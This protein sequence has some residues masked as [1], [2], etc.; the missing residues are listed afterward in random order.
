[1][2]AGHSPGRRSEAE[3]GCGKVNEKRDAALSVT[4]QQMLDQYLKHVDGGS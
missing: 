4:P 2:E 1:M 3:G